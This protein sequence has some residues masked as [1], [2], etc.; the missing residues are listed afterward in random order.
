MRYFFHEEE[1]P[2][3]L[4]SY[5]V[6]ALKSVIIRRDVCGSTQ[7]TIP[8]PSLICVYFLRVQAYAESVPCWRKATT[9]GGK[10]RCVSGEALGLQ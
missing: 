5:Q 6:S 8:H 10:G 7:R 4:I 9:E 2:R 1:I 3:I